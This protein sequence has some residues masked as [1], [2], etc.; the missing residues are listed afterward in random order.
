MSVSRDRDTD[1]DAGDALPWQAWRDAVCDTAVDEGLRA[2]WADVEA[3]IAARSPTCWI[4]GRCCKFETFGHRLYVTGLETAWTLRQLEQAGD[5]AAI[6]LAATSEVSLDGCVFQING[7]CSVHA[8]RPL[9]CRLFFCQQGTEQWQQDLYE[10]MLKRLRSLHE[11]H[12]LAYV[13]ADWRWLL[14]LGGAAMG[15][16]GL[17]DTHG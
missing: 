4:S 15:R 10:V 7:M 12:G 1:A 8:I 13:Y 2:I 3:A 6:R 11:L 17:D 14:G 9:G 5:A 16:A